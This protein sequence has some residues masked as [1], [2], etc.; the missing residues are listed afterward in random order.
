VIDFGFSEEQLALRDL[1]RELFERESPPSR[2]RQL[3]TQDEPRDDKVWRTMA[4]AGL[5]GIT[6]PE[7]HGG[8]GGDDVDLAL[9]LEEAGRAALPEPFLETVALAAPLLADFGTDAQLDEWLSR[10]ASGEAIAT[11]QPGGAPFVVDADIADLVI[12]ER[13]GELHAVPAD[14]IRSSRVESAD[15]ARRL[16]EVEADL[17]ASTRMNGGAN[18]ARIRGA[19]AVAGVL[20]GIAANLL[21]M[22]LDHVKSRTQFDRPV[23]SFQAVKHKLANVDVMVESSRA[24]AWYAAYALT[25]RSPDL[26]RAASVAKAGAAEAEHLA[27]MEALQCHGG[28]GFTWEH[29]LHFWLKRGLALEPAYGS[30]AEHRARLGRTVVTE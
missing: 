24:S 8:L 20:N 26:E 30:A 17:D 6:V 14:R 22:S 25:T 3:F 28:I 10:I 4:E 11:V 13:E 15:R 9:V 19:V 21:D 23:G 16:F 2:L 5:L 12:V 27:N 18:E 29:D 7:R 1:A